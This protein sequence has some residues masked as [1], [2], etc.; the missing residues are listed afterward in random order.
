MGRPP[1]GPHF[2]SMAPHASFW[3]LLLLLLL[4]LLY[5]SG[6]HPQR[7][8]SLVPP[9]WRRRS[10]PFS[11]YPVLPPPHAFPHSLIPTGPQS[12]LPPHAFPT[13][14]RTHSESITR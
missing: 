8:S 4:L 5:D 14:S 3:L 1:G 13:H 6:T 11:S 10:C 12:C 7:V 9:C 2:C